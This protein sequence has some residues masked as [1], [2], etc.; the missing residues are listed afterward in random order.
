MQFKIYS[1]IESIIEELGKDGYFIVQKAEIEHHKASLEYLKNRDYTYL[2]DSIQ[3]NFDNKPK[4]AYVKYFSV[5]TYFLH[6]PL[7]RTFIGGVV[8]T[9]VTEEVNTT[10]TTSPSVKLEVVNVLEGVAVPEFVPFTFH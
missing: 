7:S 8:K 1:T 6:L 4:E 10:V 9:Q 2:I 5:R 3:K